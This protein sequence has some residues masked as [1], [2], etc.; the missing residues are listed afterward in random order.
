MAVRVI[1]ANRN[2]GGAASNDPVMTIERPK[3]R[4]AA[5]CRVSTDQEEQES[6]YEAQIKHYTEFINNNSSWT[7]AGIYA[8][9]GIS[10]TQTKKRE[11][12]NAMIADCDAGLIDMV[13]TKSISRFARNTLDCLQYIRKLKDLGIP[14]LFEKENINTLDA[15][16][17][18]LITIMASIA[19]QE[20]QSISQNVR[21]G[22]Q[23][24]FQ[25][26]R[27]M[28]QHNWFLGYTKE[29]G[30]DLEIVPEEADA[31]RKV[32]RYFLEGMTIGDI[33]KK[34]EAQGIKTG[35]GKDT[36]YF[37]TIESM[38]RNE[39]YMGDLVLQ[40]GYTVDFL[41]KKKVK[42]NGYFPKY[43]VENA[44]EPIVPREVFMQ[45]Q[46]E[47]L[48]REGIKETTGK[49]EVHFGNLALNNR[50]V[51]SEC[52]KTYK[53]VRAPKDE[54]TTWRCRTRMQKGTPCHGRIVKEKA[55]HE[56]V[57]EALNKLPE[58][59]K[60]LE[61]MQMKIDKSPFVNVHDQVEA[62]ENEEEALQDEMSRY[63]EDGTLDGSSDEGG[64]SEGNGATEKR[65][66]EISKRLKEI[67]TE[68]DNLL[69]GKAE[70]D[71]QSIHTRILT[72]LIDAMEGKKIKKYVPTS[73]AC[74]DYTDFFERTKELNHHGPITE[75]SN[76]DVLRYVEKVVVYQD[77]MEIVFKAGIVIP[78]EK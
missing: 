34:M 22:I 56:A 61:M 73:A 17:E 31:V 40:K 28:L 52:G 9:E 44:Q 20:S 15:K 48:R 46:S 57:V 70:Y 29:R 55:V 1:P 19:Q 38:L 68:K 77:R 67:K 25:Q 42:N 7:L 51:C 74:Y 62:L 4:V 50:I 36:W 35:A 16:G 78:I 2:T 59:R 54:N 24:R 21:M 76:E 23:Y 13:I 10:G 37:S 60:D 3:T 5:Y 72:E 8:D 30:G 33:G 69:S 26:G 49:R 39:K 14:I 47:F 27:P 45:V 65:L 41:S 43:Y 18:L 75:F 32:F 53:R 12:F 63:A 11:R 58:K 64:E 6:S 66:A 71:I